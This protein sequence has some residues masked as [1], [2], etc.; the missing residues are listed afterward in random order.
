MA[1]FSGHDLTCHRGARPVFHGLDFQVEAGGVLLLTGANGSGKTSLLRL[2]AG[3][4]RPR[5]GHVAWNGSDIAD[6]PD[7]HGARVGYLGHLD[8]VKPHLS[9][10]EN[11]GFWCRLAGLADNASAAADRALD[12]MG[13]ARLADVPG[14]FLSAGQRRRVNLA[15][16]IAQAPEIWLLDEPTTALDAATTA[17]LGTVMAEARAGGALMVCA[18]HV[19]LGL[20][21]APSLDLG[22]YAVVCDSGAAA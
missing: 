20:A 7:A 22:D 16:V 11:L 12:A 5:H 17:A 8:T 13:I 21:D 4:A 1:T 9:V 10:A 2:M 3:L 15:R 14:R 6:D 19:E 18:T